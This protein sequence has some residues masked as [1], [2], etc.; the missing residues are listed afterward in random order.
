MTVRKIL[1]TKMAWSVPKK[2][3]QLART[4]APFHYCL[5]IVV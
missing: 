1:L 5:K 4:G 3:E 2:A